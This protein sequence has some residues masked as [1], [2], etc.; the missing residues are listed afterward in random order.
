MHARGI[1]WGIRAIANRIV[2]QSC[3]GA[4]GLA[5]RLLG[6]HEL[7]HRK[8][9]KRLVD[10]GLPLQSGLV[11]V[12]PLLAVSRGDRISVLPKGVIAPPRRQCVNAFTLVNDPQGVIK[13]ELGVVSYALV[14]P[15]GRGVDHRIKVD[16]CMVGRGEIADP[17]NSR[18]DVQ[19]VAVVVIG[20]IC[21]INHGCESV[22]L[23]G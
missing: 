14:P 11:T 4:D 16:L 7:K 5:A 18:S 13:A 19:P 9:L 1:N 20:V 22:I 6:E 2:V 12:E 8:T 17:A 23:E 3:M 15:V 10:G 21:Q